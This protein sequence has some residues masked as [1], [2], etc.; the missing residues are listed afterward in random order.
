MWRFGFGVFSLSFVVLKIK[1]VH[2]TAQLFTVLEQGRRANLSIVRFIQTRG[3]ASS[4]YKVVET[5]QMVLAAKG[6]LVE[7]EERWNEM[8]EVLG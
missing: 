2:L 4:F 8:C 1:A 7:D 6:F 3:A 5:V